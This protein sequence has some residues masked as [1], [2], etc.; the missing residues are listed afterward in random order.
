MTSNVGASTLKKQKSLGFSINGD[1]TSSEY[2]KMKENIM[3]EL[4]ISFKPEFLNRIDDIIV[5]H[6]LEQG[7][8]YKIVEIMLEVV[9]RRLKQLK[10]NINFN[11][12]TKKHLAK[13]GLNTNYGARPL[14]RE[15]TKAVE[16][17]LSEEILRGNINKGD[18][19][20]VTMKN[21]E[22]IFKTLHN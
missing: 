17:V 5:F 21:G 13:A 15:I 1:G 11:D 7:D 9:K 14:R 18:N 22:L 6:S 12:E 10:I 2:D 4:R 16:D 3:D 20:N 8:L 19:V